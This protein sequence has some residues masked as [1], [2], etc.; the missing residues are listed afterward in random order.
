MSLNRCYQER[1]NQRLASVH[2]TLEKAKKRVDQKAGPQEE[3]EG[4]RRSIEARG[5]WRRPCR[6]AGE[7]NLSR[8]QQTRGDTTPD[9]KRRQQKLQTILATMG[10]L[11]REASVTR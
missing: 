4:E 7:D 8:E 5:L 3:A 9:V 6:K 11:A 2:R 1:K 10:Q